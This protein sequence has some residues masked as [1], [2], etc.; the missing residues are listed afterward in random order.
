MSSNRRP[1]GRSV[2]APHRHIPNS[3]ADAGSGSQPRMQACG[4]RA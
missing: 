2:G 4:D 1:T 3:W